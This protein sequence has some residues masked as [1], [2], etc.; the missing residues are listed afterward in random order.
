M[1][2][3]TTQINGFDIIAHSH[4][5][6]GIRQE[7]VILGHRAHADHAHEYVVTTVTSLAD[8]SWGQGGYT[9]SL[10]SAVQAYADRGG[11]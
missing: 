9:R 8:T 10:S 2:T 6:H 5:D 7:I 3:Q 11:K 4:V 1:S